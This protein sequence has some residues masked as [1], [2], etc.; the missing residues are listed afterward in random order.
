M[1]SR[2]PNL[3]QL[4]SS[5]L[6]PSSAAYSPRLLCQCTAGTIGG[7]STPAHAGSV[8]A[9]GLNGRLVAVSDDGGAPWEMQNLRKNVQDVRFRML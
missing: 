9:K 2:G 1:M 8:Q 6:L 7:H 5:R 3:L 4:L